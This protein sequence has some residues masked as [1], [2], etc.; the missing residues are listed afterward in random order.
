MLFGLQ[1]RELLHTRP[2]PLT[3]AET[4]RRRASNTGVIIVAGQKLALGLIH[5]HQTVTVTVFGDSA[6]PCMECRSPTARS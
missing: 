4:G 3:D 1:T 6:Q 5:Q 2:N